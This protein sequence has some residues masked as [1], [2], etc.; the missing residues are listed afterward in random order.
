MSDEDL[1]LILLLDDWDRPD[2]TGWLETPGSV[3]DDF[4]DLEVMYE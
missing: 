4:D 1:L 3:L 2:G